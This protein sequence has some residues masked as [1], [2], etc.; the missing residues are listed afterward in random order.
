LT[1]AALRPIPG[2]EP[3]ITERDV[4][5]FDRAQVIPFPIVERHSAPA[6]S[7]RLQPKKR[8][9]FVVSL[10]GEIVWRFRGGKGFTPYREPWDASG[11]LRV[12]GRLMTEPKIVA[13]ARELEAGRR[14]K[15]DLLATNGTRVWT[16]Y[17]HG[18][19]DVEPGPGPY[20]LRAA[21]E[22]AAAGADVSGSNL[23][24]VRE[25]HEWA[26]PLRRLADAEEPLGPKLDEPE[27]PEQIWTGQTA[28]QIYRLEL[29]E[30]KT[31]NR[32][33]VWVPGMP[34][35]VNSGRK[36]NTS[37]FRNEVTGEYGPHATVGRDGRV[38]FKNGQPA[39]N[40]G[41]VRVRGLR[42]HSQK[43]RVRCADGKVRRV[44]AQR[45]VERRGRK[46]KF[47]N[48]MTNAERQRL[49]RARKRE[50][51]EHSPDG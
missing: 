42:D 44:N 18:W 48:A 12:R 7:Y 46:P 51:N 25:H 31:F 1:K 29:Q 33:R 14:P 3:K 40:R 4:P 20:V 15:D 49:F 39:L 43:A 41:G 30:R 13:M 50:K 35:H 47:G 6:V 36:V 27:R 5:V 9:Q 26:K 24:G 16:D 17:P 28:R 8:K 37:E 45:G 2:Q 10:T 21:A 11:L 23:P 19:N 32:E 22:L 34:M 38:L